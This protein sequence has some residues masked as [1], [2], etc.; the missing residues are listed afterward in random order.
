[1]GTEKKLIIVGGRSL[2]VQEF[3]D[4]LLEQQIPI[5]K[6]IIVSEGDRCGEIHE[7]DNTPILIGRLEDIPE[8][9]FDAAILMSPI[10]NLKWLLE[11]MIKGKIPII[12]ASGSV[13]VIPQVP[14][15]IPGFWKKGVPLPPVSISPEMITLLLALITLPIHKEY[16]IQSIFLY[17]IQGTSQ[18]GSKGAM[19]ELF[20][21]TRCIMN[22]K[23]VD[24][25]EFPKQIAF[26]IFPVA[27]VSGLAKRITHELFMILGSES[28]TFNMDLSWGAFFIGLTGTLWIETR[29]EVDI[30]NILTLFSQLPEL[31]ASSGETH[32]SILDVVGEDKIVLNN[33]HQYHPNKRGLTLRFTLDNL[34][35]GYIANLVHMIKLL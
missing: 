27:G 26:N 22:F 30:E 35:K 3:L 32:T 8:D 9:N 16:D 18:H 10:K 23:E 34:R 11:T 4:R 33:I 7:M 20:N 1:M 15:I 13:Q 25:N 17:G 12:D 21:Q 5:E 19:D 28:F 29:K 6:I 14:V 31:N 24:I 2:H